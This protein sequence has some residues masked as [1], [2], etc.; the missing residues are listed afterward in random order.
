MIIASFLRNIKQFF[1][2]FK[3]IYNLNMVSYEEN[4]LAKRPQ[5]LCKMC[6]RCCRLVTIPQSYDEVKRMASEGNSAAKDFLDLFEPYNSIDDARAVDSATVDNVIKLFKLDG[7]YDEKKMIFYHCR[8]IQPDNLCSNYKNRRLLCK[9]FP[10][11]P[12]AIVPPGC[13]F[14]GWLFWRREEIKQQVRK[15]KEELLE[16]SFLKQKIKDENT[17]KRISLVEEKLRRNIDMYK[18]YGSS[19]W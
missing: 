15:E 17:L 4:Y 1:I 7:K 6:G 12:W 19:D 16:L 5:H 9:H 8:F 13:G 14:E 11:T 10:S 3:E 18:K 2:F